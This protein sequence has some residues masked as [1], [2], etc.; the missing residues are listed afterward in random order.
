MRT[1]FETLRQ[2][3]SYTLNHL[4]ENKMIDFNVASRLDLIEAMATELGLAS[5]PM[6]T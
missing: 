4:K 6:R 5:Q 3:A 2:L 1:D